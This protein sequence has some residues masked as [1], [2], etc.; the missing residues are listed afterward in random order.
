MSRFLEVSQKSS[1]L[2][3]EV[4][5]Y[6]AELFGEGRLRPPITALLGQTDKLSHELSTTRS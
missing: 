4:Q 2:C 1:P 3:P 5:L 6:C